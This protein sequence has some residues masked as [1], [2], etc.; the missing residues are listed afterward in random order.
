MKM[1]FSGTVNRDRESQF[2]IYWSQII[3]FVLCL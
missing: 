1:N 3:L 2:K